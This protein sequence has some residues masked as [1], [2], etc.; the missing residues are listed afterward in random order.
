MIAVVLKRGLKCDVIQ[1]DLRPVA[2]RGAFMYRLYAPF[3]VE[4]RNSLSEKWKKFTVPEGFLCDGASSPRFLWTLTGFTRDG[5][6]RA[7]ALV[8]DWLYHNKGW[9]HG[10]EHLDGDQ[11]SRKECD[12]MFF[13]ILRHYGVS[14]WKARGAY[15]AVRAFGWIYWRRKFRN[16]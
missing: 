11:L 4:F 8:H 12:R 1:P 3:S 7:A 5:M 6:H 15:A 13:L 2:E 10:Y 14:D 16:V 9:T